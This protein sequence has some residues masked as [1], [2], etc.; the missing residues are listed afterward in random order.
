[1]KIRLLRPFVLIG[2]ALAAVPAL[3]ET[4][5][6][7]T[8]KLE[9]GG[10]FTLDTELGKVTVRGTSGSGVRLVVTSRRDDIDD[11][12]S[13]RYEEGARSAAV[14]SRV[15]TSR[16]WVAHLS[17]WSRGSASHGPHN[18]P[19]AAE[20][21]APVGPE[22]RQSESRPPRLGPASPSHELS[23][24]FWIASLNLWAWA[25]E[26]GSV[27]TR[28]ITATPITMAQTLPPGPPRALCLIQ[29]P[30]P[31]AFS[32]NRSEIQPQAGISCRR[33]SR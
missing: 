5:M 33:R 18:A 26:R 12:L 31:S 30:P 7:K 4:R 1:M 24:A 23:R 2:L 14:Q 15:R 19:A 17:T 29:Y 16:V 22:A 21:V 11:L 13:F 3:A 20:V 10:Q 25:S 9:P 32:T 6:E 27:R 8:L 28:A